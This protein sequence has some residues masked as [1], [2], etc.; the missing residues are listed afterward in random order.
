MCGKKKDRSPWEAWFCTALFP[1]TSGKFKFIVWIR[2]LFYRKSNL[3]ILGINENE[4]HRDSKTLQ[5]VNLLV[6][7]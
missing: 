7:H 3:F 2:D 5:L 1:K 6:D 4:F